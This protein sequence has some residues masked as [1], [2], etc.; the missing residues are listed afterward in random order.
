[1]ELAKGEMTDASPGVWCSVEKLGSS[2]YIVIILA[3]SLVRGNAPISHF[4]PNR[5]SV[6][7][8]SDLGEGKNR[9]W[10]KL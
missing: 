8:Y 7:A 9:S 5:T 2:G 4:M 1:M 3:Y 6:V 10:H